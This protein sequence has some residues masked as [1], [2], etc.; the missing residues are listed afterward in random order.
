[1][2]APAACLFDLDGLLLDTEPCH[3]RAWLEAAAH[4]GVE[5]EEGQLLQLRGRRRQENARQ[6]CDWIAAGTGQIGRA[7]V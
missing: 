6:V 5:L 2:S 3:G 7:H 4:F 1:M